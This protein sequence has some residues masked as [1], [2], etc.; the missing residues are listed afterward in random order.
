MRRAASAPVVVLLAAWVL[1][2]ASGGLGCGTGGSAGTGSVAV[3][4]TDAPSD[5]FERIE[6]VI[7][8]VEL[9][10]ASRV[11]IFSGR[12]TVD[13]RALA[14][15]SNP[16]FVATDV[17]V[18]AYEKVRLTIDDVSLIRARAGGRRRTDGPTLHPEPPGSGLIDLV[19]RG[20][21]FVVPGATLVMEIDVDAE[22]AIRASAPDPGGYGM[23]PVAFLRVLDDGEQ[24]P[25]PARVHGMIHEF[26]GPR[27][28]ALCS[29]EIRATRRADPDASSTASCLAVNL[30][31][32]TRVYTAPGR[33]VDVAELAVG[34]PV[35]VVGDVRLQRGGLQLATTRGR[36][37]GEVPFALADLDGADLQL[38][39]LA[40]ERGPKGRAFQD[41]VAELLDLRAGALVR[42]DPAGRRFELALESGRECVDV[43]PDAQLLL[44]ADDGR[45]ASASEISLDDLVDGQSVEVFGS[46]GESCFEAEALVAVAAVGGVREAAD[47]TDS[48]S[49]S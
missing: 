29:D 22:K 46:R 30:S 32:E 28:F 44:L 43:V 1:A 42:L 8:R 49:D 48:G 37:L 2:G 26:L 23:R 18:G 15:F 12:K 10:G 17:P 27:G 5:D 21:F 45:V 25:K 20:A 7:S 14:S 19:P 36:S 47:P 3:L 13:L 39:A 34:D 6:L 33:R 40:V 4:V 11:E 35:T 9:L 24:I 16:L 41:A 38:D 31:D